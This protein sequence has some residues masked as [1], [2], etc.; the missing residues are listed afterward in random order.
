MTFLYFCFTVCFP[1]TEL[2]C[3]WTLFQI[4]GTVQLISVGKVVSELRIMFRCSCCIGMF[5]ES[6]RNTDIYSC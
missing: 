4:H 2:L 1:Y 6:C 5:W 3:E